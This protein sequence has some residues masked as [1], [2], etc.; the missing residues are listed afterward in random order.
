VHIH[1]K[2]SGGDKRGCREMTY[3]I[4]NGSLG[5]R[6][7]I[8]DGK[9]IIGIAFYN[10]EGIVIQTDRGW[11]ERADRGWLEQGNPASIRRTDVNPLVLVVK[12]V[13]KNK[14]DYPKLYAVGKV[15]YA[16]GKI[17]Y[18]VIMH[19]VGYILYIPYI[20]EDW[21][22]K[23]GYVLHSTT[24]SEYKSYVHK[25]EGYV[26]RVKTGETPI[27]DNV[28]FVKRVRELFKLGVLVERDIYDVELI[29]NR[30]QIITL[31]R[32]LAV[33]L[34]RPDLLPDELEIV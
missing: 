19:E 7:Y 30:E 5:R 22:V 8:I 24:R 2:K 15:F 33:T 1:I 32:K 9:E 29:K 20:P 14:V 11:L 17:P 12:P 16:K 23:R 18:N 31:I 26:I 4:T 34:D 13:R 3:V 25:K 21:A 28:V 10:R 6:R 27:E